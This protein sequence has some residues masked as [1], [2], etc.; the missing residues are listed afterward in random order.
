MKYIEHGDKIDENVKR[1]II[2]HRYFRHPNIVI[3]TPTHLAIVLEYASGELFE[4]ICNAWCFSEDNLISGVSYCHSMHPALGV[5]LGLFLPYFLPFPPL[6]LL[7]SF[8]FIGLHPGI[9]DFYFYPYFKLN[10]HEN[11]SKQY[12]TM[13]I[14]FKK[15]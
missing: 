8:V 10:R 4:R 2:N 12:M 6:N 3:L 9:I 7:F 14:T 13:K 5:A 15:Y 1:E 11:A